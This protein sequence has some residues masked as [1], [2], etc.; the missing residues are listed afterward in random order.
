MASEVTLHASRNR[1]RRPA[2]SHARAAQFDALRWAQFFAG[3]ALGALVLLWA[4]HA[5]ARSAPESFA[6][7]AEQVLPAVVNVS[8]TQKVPQDQ[9]MQEFDEMFRDFLD[10]RDGA[11]EPGPRGGP[12]SDPASSSI[13]T[14]TSSPTT[15]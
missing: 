8:S 2:R 1:A 10:R 4:G 15:M 6:D 5:L 7:L 3:L 11:P 9:Q 13:R 14:A 12:R